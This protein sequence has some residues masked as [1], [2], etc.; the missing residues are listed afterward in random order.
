MTISHDPCIAS[1]INEKSISHVIRSDIPDSESLKKIATDHYEKLTSNS[2]QKYVTTDEGLRNF[3]EYGRIIECPPVIVVDERLPMEYRKRFLEKLIG[4]IEEDRA[5]II[6]SKSFMMPNMSI[7]LGES[8]IQLFCT[9]RDFPENM[10]YCG[11]AMINLNDKRLRKDLELFVEY[12][13]ANGGIYSK[14][15]SVDYLS[16]LLALCDGREKAEALQ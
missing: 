11:N 3:A 5:L 16:N 1:I 13:Q 2:E 12:I 15:M 9:F 14:K 7:E 4:Y 8:N 10:Q 6:D